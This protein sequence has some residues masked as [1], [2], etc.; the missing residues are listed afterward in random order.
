MCTEYATYPLPHTD[1]IFLCGDG[2]GSGEMGGG[3]WGWGEGGGGGARQTINVNHHNGNSS[4]S[5]CD[6]DE[7]AVQVFFPEDES[8]CGMEA[9]EVY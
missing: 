4:L 1:M 7:L 3:K 2:L 5:P 6:N 8:I 9:T